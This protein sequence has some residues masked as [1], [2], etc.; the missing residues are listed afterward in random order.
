MGRKRL[1][2]I[3]HRHEL[4]EF[5]MDKISHCQNDRIKAIHWYIRVLSVMDLG[6]NRQGL[7]YRFCFHH[8]LAQRSQHLQGVKVPNCIDGGHSAI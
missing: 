3:Q 7:V 5:V 6:Q 1:G 8:C 4:E 2:Y